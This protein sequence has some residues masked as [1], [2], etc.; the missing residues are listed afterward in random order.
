MTQITILAGS[1]EGELNHSIGTL[2]AL[3]ECLVVEYQGEADEG[4]EGTGDEDFSV[5]EDD[6]R[7]FGHL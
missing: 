1:A 2:P 7:C 4:C 5:R 3:V 6:D